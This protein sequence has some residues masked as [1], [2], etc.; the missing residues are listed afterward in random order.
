ME[1]LLA[2]V[3]AAVIT[4]LLSYIV[5]N[6]YYQVAKAKLH[7]IADALQVLDAAMA[8]DKIDK[9]EAVKIYKAFQAVVKDP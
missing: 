1:D 3:I 5:G 7:A 9:A 8:D 2:S 4:L 6:H